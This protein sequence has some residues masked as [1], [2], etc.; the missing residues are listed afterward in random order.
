MFHLLL[1]PFLFHHRRPFLCRRSKLRLVLYLLIHAR[2][3]RCI[4]P[5]GAF[6]NVVFSLLVRKPFLHFRL[7]LALIAISLL[8]V[9]AVQGAVFTIDEGRIMKLYDTYLASNRK[10]TLTEKKIAAEREKVR[11]AIGNELNALVSA[12]QAG[13]GMTLAQTVE[14]QRGLV[15]SLEDQQDATEIDLDLL[16]E[17]ESRYFSF[18]SSSSSGENVP[19]SIDESR[20]VSSYPELLAKRLILEERDNALTSILSVQEERLKKLSFQ[21]KIDQVTTLAG[22]GK[23]VII[24]LLVFIVERFIRMTFLTRIENRNRRYAAM[25]IFTATTYVVMVVWLIAQL[26]SEHPGFV[27]SFAI[28]GAGVAIALQ[29]IIKDFFGWLVIVQKRMFALGQRITIGPYTGDVIDI[30]P[31]R[32]TLMEVHNSSSPDIGRF[33]QTLYLPNSFFLRE[34]ILNFHATSDFVEAEINLV[35]SSESSW[36]EA[37]RILRE[38]LHAETDQ[39]TDRARRQTVSRTQHFYVSQDALGARVFME[40]GPRGIVFTLR[41]LVPI[42]ERRLTITKL[43]GMILDKFAEANPKIELV[44]KE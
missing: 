40:A 34:P 19:P 9:V 33:G 23:Y 36:K 41:F 2:R 27:T 39:F 25:K 6:A 18:A 3:Q 4:K 14:R 1:L 35:V 26:S 5:G 30:S 28:I 15:K 21:Q 32:T 22:I 11:T 12:A 38:I 8:P 37:D 7:G 42:G 31:L 17:E 29:D 43:T 24:I 16:Q 20:I 44:F 13:S 10:D